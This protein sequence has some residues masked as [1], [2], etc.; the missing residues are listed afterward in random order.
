MT[1]QNVDNPGGDP[2]E[3]QVQQIADLAKK[4]GVEFKEQEAKQWILAMTTAEHDSVVAQDNQ[5]GIFGH[6][7]SLLDFDTRELEYFRRLAVKT[8]MAKHP[9]VES[10]IAI[11][12][13]AAQGK[14]Q[15]FPGDND[16]YERVNIHAA[17]EKQARHIL[18]EI[19]RATALRS[20]KEPDIVLVD[21]D[22]GT[23]PFDVVSNGR[24]WK[25]GTHIQWTPTDVLNGYQ[26][27][28]DA[29]GNTINLKWEDIDAGVGFVYL[30]WII[31]D[32]QEGRIGLAS[33]VVD[34]TWE[35]PDGTIEAL[36]GSIDAFFQEIYLDA[37]EMP[38]FT[39]V[40]SHVASDALGTYVNLMRGQ[41]RHYAHEEVNY[42][43]VAKRLYN[44]FR[45]TD[46]LE[47][48]AYVRELFDEPQAR[49]YQVP[50]LLE[51]ADAARD[52]RS[53]IEQATVLQQL[54]H[55]I[56]A[57]IEIGVGKPEA[58]LVLQLVYLR[59]DIKDNADSPDAKWHELLDAVT[60]QC[61]TLINEYFRERLFAL[62]E[63]A[64]YLNGLNV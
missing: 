55:I 43:K 34:A 48:A 33:N 18:G 9:Q 36:D 35:A 21:V 59:D 4:E 57:V 63:I 27:V 17:T 38:V 8:R 40:T 45:L 6:H 16:F 3:R 26:T 31:A 13:S 28:Q 42:G 51:A 62:P 19:V 53:G 61:L 25:A 23:Y 39:K 11:A 47:A 15:L 22:L 52:Q 10:A 2:V 1:A 46:Q 12:G 58:E 64:E 41:V 20:F 37:S 14:V 5:T 44:L 56:R 29:Q 7:V 49:L 54:D 24:P 30:G 50:G 32:R 60:E